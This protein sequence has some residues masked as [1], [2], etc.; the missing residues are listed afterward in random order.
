MSDQDENVRI[1]EV[2]GVKLE[3]DLRNA[4]R[5]DTFKVGDSVRVLEK[6][7]SDRYVT[8]FGVI[9]D[10]L[11]FEKRPAIEILVV[12]PAKYSGD[13]LYFKTITHDS[14]DVE[15]AP[16]GELDCLFSRDDVLENLN[17]DILKKQ[18]E[19]RTLK[20]KQEIFLERFGQFFS[21]EQ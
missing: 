13:P 6:E 19:V 16:M 2:N 3:V 4:K 1:I 10:F 9:V 20:R 21:K 7:Y 12:D 5:V 18:E 15:I 14:E 11:E 17:R 8:R